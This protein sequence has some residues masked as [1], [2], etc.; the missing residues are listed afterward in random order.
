MPS[1][2]SILLFSYLCSFSL[3]RATRPRPHQFTFFFVVVLEQSVHFVLAVS[4][5]HVWTRRYIH[6]SRARL[7]LRLR[8]RQPMPQLDRYQLY[9][10]YI[11]VVTI[12]DFIKANE[13]A[14]RSRILQTCRHKTDVDMLQVGPVV[15]FRHVRKYISFSVVASP[16]STFPRRSF[17]RTGYSDIALT[18]VALATK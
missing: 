13:L 3:Q 7:S 17:V 5:S 10:E 12:A 9:I 8:D 4:I 11:Y 14:K 15:Q 16:G 1:C 2:F 6:N 18:S